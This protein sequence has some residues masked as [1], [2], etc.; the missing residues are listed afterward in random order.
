M[1]PS[2]TSNSK[3]S[4]WRRVRGDAIRIGLFLLLLE[5]VIQVRPV[6]TMLEQRLGT[7]ENLLWY[8]SRMP[9]YKLQL[10]ANPDYTF[11]LIGSS[12]MMTGLDPALIQAKLVARGHQ[13]VTVQNYGFTT[14]LNLSVMAQVVDNWLLELDQ[15][16]YVVIGI[17]DLNFGREILNRMRI[18]D[19]PAEQIFI[20]PDSLDDYIARFLYRHS[21]LYRYSILGRNATLIPFEQTVRRVQPNGGYSPRD[22]IYDCAEATARF[23]NGPTGLEVPVSV[24]LERF[25]ELAEVLEARE[26]PVIIVT[27]PLARCYLDARYGSLD[28]Y[29][30]AYL[31]P[32]IEFVNDQLQLPIVVTDHR[33]YELPMNEQNDLFDNGTHSNKKG[34]QFLSEQLLIFLDN[35]FREREN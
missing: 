35:W 33:F 13:R 5:L 28:L 30:E 15:P 20:F 26:I 9:S 11:W 14:M 18:E 2:F 1:S 10:E 16:Q 34:A 22:G 7:Y 23:P 3:S 21:D 27:I 24:G 19:S 25:H 6:N 4:S 31:D 32:V 29:N 12:P 8:D 17:S